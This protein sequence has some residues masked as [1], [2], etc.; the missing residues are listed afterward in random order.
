M[1]E[2]STQEK[3]SLYPERPTDKAEW[4]IEEIEMVERGEGVL[5][6]TEM[7]RAEMLDWENELG[8]ELEK[9]YKKK[10]AK[11]VFYLN[12]FLT[13]EGKRDFREVLDLSFEGETLSECRQ[14]IFENRETI[15]KEKLSKLSGLSRRS[16][17]YSNDELSKKLQQE[18]DSE[19]HINISD[20][21]PPQSV[22][23]L[24]STEKILQKN[25]EL[26]EFKQRLK[27]EWEDMKN[28]ERGNLFEAKK[29]IL[30]LYLRKVNELIARQFQHADSISTMAKHCDLTT[31]E[32]DILLETFKF[33]DSSRGHSRYDKFIYGAD[34]EYNSSGWREQISGK[35]KK[36]VKKI[37]SLFNANEFKKYELLKEKG[38]DLKAILKEDIPEE[39]FSAWVKEVLG[40]YGVGDEWKFIT[41][42]EIK[43]MATKT[44]PKE[45]HSGNTDKS[46][47]KVITVLLGHE[48]EGHVLQ[49]LN[50]EQINLRLFQKMKGDRY[51]IFSEMGPMYVQNLISKEAFGFEAV[52][53]PYYIQ[54]MIKKLEGG[55]YLDCVKVY[56]E[57]SKKLILEKK[58]QGLISDEEMD[59]ELKNRLKVAVKSVRR[60]FMPGVDLAKTGKQ[61]LRSRDTVYLE[62]KLIA[63]ELAKRGLEKYIFLTGVN[64]VT[65][66]DLIKIGVVDKDKIQTPK[67]YSLKKWEEV[68]DRHG[69]KEG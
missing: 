64:L 67:L 53:R 47:Y 6:L 37:E 2:I 48:I 32:K 35:L 43:S 56:Y 14:F 63:E 21:E 49:N 54:A 52:P 65:L 8:E 7:E 17:N 22:S 24:I 38:L 1:R 19:G 12:Y 29:I 28:G 16:L 69:E 33:S 42:P 20:I 27:A 40:A 66:I 61:L 41:K 62:Q 44:G 58:E 55:N 23:L 60:L 57:S 31:E 51:S 4:F 25:R 18:I 10:T 5:D 30:G 39:V 11:R 59:K 34:T 36:T 45:I 9:I 68:K 26:R 50:S 15:R 13:E 3:Q 46:I